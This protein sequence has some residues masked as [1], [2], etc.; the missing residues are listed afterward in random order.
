MITRHGIIR[1][2][3]PQITQNFLLELGQRDKLA[4]AAHDPRSSLPSDLGQ[5]LRNQFLSGL[6]LYNGELSFGESHYRVPARDALLAREEK[7]YVL[8]GG[9]R[10]RTGVGHRDGD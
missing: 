9:H 5:V 4:V 3:L 8:L 10:R 6:I 7:K 1:R 2:L